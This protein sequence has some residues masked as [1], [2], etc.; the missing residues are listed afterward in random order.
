MKRWSLLQSRRA[1]WIG[2]CLTLP[3]CGLLCWQLPLLLRPASALASAA[4]SGETAATGSADGQGAHPLAAA[5]AGRAALSITVATARSLNWP[6]TLRL[7]GTVAP[8]MEASIGARVGGLPLAEVLVNVG[9]HVRKGQLLAR[10]DDVTLRAELGQL[11][12]ALEQAEAAAGQ[13]EAN[14]ERALRIRDSGALSEQ[15]ILQY[16]TQAATARAQLAQARAQL[17]ASELKLAFTRV[18]AP[19]DGIISQRN[20]VLGSIGQPGGSELFRLIRQGR[21]EWRAEVPAD[22]LSRLHAGQRAR[23]LLPDGSQAEGRLRQ[24]GAGLDPNTRLGLAYVDLSAGSAALPAMYLEGEFLSAARPAL[25]VPAEA[26]VIRDGRSYVVRIEDGRGH[27]VAVHTGRRQ[28]GQIELLDG[29][30]AGQQVAVK[31]AGFL[32]DNDP[33]LE[34]GGSAS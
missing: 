22:Q 6:Q 12:A 26:L 24:L 28:E 27:L 13:A 9:D 10:Y 5:S 4:G 15:D 7:S 8:W 25:V 16:L 11:R 3:V 32:N 29:I 23:V 20:A 21:M 19:D 14:R 17:D 1:R 2:L 30:S 31:G 18:E 34:Q 33:V